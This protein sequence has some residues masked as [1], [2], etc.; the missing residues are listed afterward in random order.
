MKPSLRNRRRSAPPRRFRHLL[1]EQL[2]VR[3]L[4]AGLIELG[5]SDNIAL[6]QPRVAMELIKDVNPDPNVE[7]WESVGP[8]VFNTFLLDTGANS[9]LAMAT[10]VADMEGPPLAYETEYKYHELGVGGVHE[11]DLSAAYRMDFAGTS[12]ERNTLLDTRILSDP[13]KD[14]SIFGPWGIVG[15][16]AMVNRV[17]SFD[18][19]GWSGG[20]TGLEDLYMK[21]AFA[22]D[23]P[24][25][26][27]PPAESHRYKIQ[28]DNDPSFDPAAGSVEDTDP[29][30]VW[31]DVPF[32]TVI[33]THHGVGQE[34]NFLFDTGAQISLIS[35][36]LAIDIGL[37]SNGDGE[38]NE[39]DDSFVTH[40][41]VGGVG[42]V[43]NA[44]VFEIDEVR[45]PVT[46]DSTG[47]ELEL[48]WTDLQWLVLDIHPDIEGVFGSD[49]LTSGWFHA[50][51]YPGQPDGY[52]D[53]VHLDFRDMDNG[54]GT[55]Y[56]DLNAGVDEV[57]DPGPGIRIRGARSIDVAEGG[58]DDTYSVVLTSEP[59]A[60]VTVTLGNTDGQV[61]AVKGDPSQSNQLV[62]DSTN[63]SMPQVVRVTANDDDVAEGNHTGVITHTITSTDGDYTN[64]TVPD[65]TVNVTDDDLHLITIT[66]DQAG[67]TVIDSI[68][69]AEGGTATYWVALSTEP[70]PGSVIYVEL[71]DSMSQVSPTHN[72]GLLT[73]AVEFTDSNWNVPQAV[74]VAGVDDALPE[75]PHQTQIVHTV[76]DFTDI[77][78][79]LTLGQSNFPVNVS[80][81]DI[82][83]VVITESDGSTDLSEAGG[84]DTYE[85][86]L[87]TP[88]S[89]AVHITVTADSQTQVSIDGTDF[90]SSLDLTFNST[91][92]QAITLRAVDDVVDEGPHTG[93]ITHAVT[94]PV[95][96]S[97]YPTTLSI[98]NVTAAITDNDSAGLRITSDQQGQNV[99][100][101]VN[102]A[103]GGTE[104]TYWVALRSQPSADVS[105]FLGNSDGQISAVDDD[106]DNE[107]RFTSANW[108]TPQR[109]HVNAVDDDVVEGAHT[110]QIIHGAVSIDP[111]YHGNVLLAAS[112][113]DNDSPPTVAITRAGPNPTNVDTVVFDVTFSKG[114]ENVN[115]SDFVL[116]RSGVTTDALASGDVTDAGDT[117]ASTYQVTVSNVAGDGTLG[118]DIATDTDI[119][120]LAGNA[121]NQTPTA[122]E[123]YTID[124]TAPSTTLTFPANGQSYND[125]GWTDSITGTASDT[126]GAS[127]A[128]VEVS[129][130]QNSTGQYF[131][132]TNAFDSDTE[133]PLAATGTTS[134]SRS[135][136]DSNFPA[137]G[138]YTVRAHATDTAGNE[139]NTATATFTYDTT[140]P[141]PVITATQT[142]PTNA[143]PINFSVDFDE[144]VND[145]VI[146][147]VTVGNGTA[148]NFATSD[149][150]TFTFDVSPAADG[151]VTVDIAASVAADLAGNDNTAA[152]QFL[153]TSD[154]TSPAPA[155]TA[156][157]TSPTNADPINFSVDFGEAVSG[158]V[159]G[160]VTVVNGSAGNFAT[161]DNQTFTFDVS[162]ASDGAVTVDIGASVATD[163]AGNT[164]AAATQFS[165]TSDQAAP[166]L[167]IGAPSAADT[168]GGPVTYTVTY[169][170]ANTIMLA[171][172]D[173]TLDKT[174]SADGTVAVSGSGLTRTVTISSITGDGTLG[175]TLAAGTASDTAGN[176]A[177]SAGP[178]STFNVDNTAPTPTIA[179]PASPT[180]S[181]PFDVTIDFGETVIGFVQ[182]DITVVNGSVTNVTDNGNG[183]F[184]ATIDVTAAGQV[185]VDVAANVADD[186]AGNANVAAAQFSLTYAADQDQDG[187]SNDTEDGAPNG[188]D[189]NDDGTADSQQPEVASFPNTVDGTYVTLATPAGTTLVGVAAIDNPSPGNAPD[190]VEFPIGFCDYTVTGVDVGGS[191][192]VT[193]YPASGAVVNVYYKYG[194]T[195]GNTNDHWY[196]FMFDGQTGAKV[197]ADRIE[198]YFVDGARGDDDLTENG[199]IVDPGAPGGT[200]F[201]WQNPV[202]PEDVNGDT[203]VTTLDVLTLITDIIAQR[204]V[205]PGTMQGSDTLPPYPD[206]EPDYLLTTLDILAVITHINAQARGGPE[207]ES[208]GRD[209]GLN[210][211]EL[212]IDGLMHSDEIATV[213]DLE[214]YDVQ[215]MPSQ[216]VTVDS[217]GD[218]TSSRPRQPD[219]RPRTVDLRD[220]QQGAEL[221]RPSRT[222]A[223]TPDL[224]SLD[225]SSLDSILEDIVPDVSRYWRID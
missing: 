47:E 213:P 192:V 33:P 65:L 143:D 63:W 183:N 89:G 95:N 105:I 223:N 155:I 167:T 1:L 32:L 202:L 49:L 28:V 120:D 164:N 108:S 181:D 97:M 52:I 204:R 199:I 186:Q 122:D 85:I 132:G 221:T 109:V 189:G 214:L 9:V 159:L 184:T 207:G 179:G 41:Q 197:F 19:T 166:T 66:E 136:A 201:L 116:D 21:V 87:A 174:G 81:N 57:I 46:K 112:I 180:G 150:Q 88:P 94:A 153:I 24:S 208:A 78:N 134:W 210:L 121:L 98:D 13:D 163:A 91:N 107:L 77:F 182:G 16:P 152:G 99:I 216:S 72:D 17:T 148:S 86:A 113:T 158:F 172:G 142:S 149:N 80:D 39:D 84:T 200:G 157:Q 119:A 14:F 173:V 194:P 140:G 58:A 93:T 38:L 15:M 145:F 222:N 82:G 215:S 79:V 62:F 123:T 144:A 137:D 126:G 129:I 225:D 22:D 217:V 170:G 219:A 209:S 100:T 51:F 127:V 117:D 44:P 92:A 111:N 2:E 34:G 27:V 73:D 12:G 76:Y 211:S 74:E 43:V 6:D 31:A 175:V 26:G 30:P 224:A 205:L 11:M 139:E 101:S 3:T 191:V 53:K 96:D 42:G 54:S 218:S 75:G 162:P 220:Q 90:S 8:S 156:T 83:A 106:A 20:G 128:T 5:A 133:V 195:L 68:D 151:A 50:F 138:D 64:L 160:D 4:L 36:T 203:L 45:V 135:F 110:D 165:I 115:F 56:L 168:T 10:A 198:L 40:Q 118:L 212:P 130:Q 60:N 35:P 169:V 37:D 206:V 154:Q 25:E 147:D 146:G 59:T 196:P 69:V 177:A 190:G 124:N 103:E 114:V 193:V 185:T 141:T 29:L 102:V 67:Q 187:V 178:S 104:A 171:D 7:Q 176:T 161:S 48:V 125:A 70:S 188:G 61:T 55:I 23:V 71:K 18:M 131:S